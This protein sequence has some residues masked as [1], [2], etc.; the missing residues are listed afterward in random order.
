MML[1]FV[2]RAELHSVPRDSLPPSF[3][4]CKLKMTGL[5]YSVNLM[6][7]VNLNSILILFALITRMGWLF[8]AFI[9][10]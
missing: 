5:G 6:L 3:F 9:L 1:A 8:F 2:S 10:F 7:A 4:Y